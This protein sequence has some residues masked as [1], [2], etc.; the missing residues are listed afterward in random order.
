MPSFPNGLGE[1]IEPNTESAALI[2]STL[3]QAGI[4]AALWGLCAAAE[5]GGDLCPLVCLALIDF[6]QRLMVSMVVGHRASCER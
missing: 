6:H 2:A 4:S 3:F 1:I 5:Y